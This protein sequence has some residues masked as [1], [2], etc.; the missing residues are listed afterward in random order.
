MWEDRW[1]VKEGGQGSWLFCVYIEPI[2]R[3]PDDLHT[4]TACRLISNTYS[5]VYLASLLLLKM[6]SNDADVPIT[7]IGANDSSGTEQN[8]PLIGSAEFNTIVRS[9]GIDVRAG[10]YDMKRELQEKYVFPEGSAFIPVSA[11]YTVKNN[12]GTQQDITHSITSQ[13]DLDLANPLRIQQLTQLDESDRHALFDPTAAQALET[14]CN[15]S[16][17]TQSS[18]LKSLEIHVKSRDTNGLSVQKDQHSVTLT[19]YTKFIVTKS[20][21][22]SQ[23]GRNVVVAQHQPEDSNCGEARFTSQYTIT[24]EGCM[25]RYPSLVGSDHSDELSDALG[26]FRGPKVTRSTVGATEAE[27]MT[28][29]RAKA[30]SLR[31]QGYKAEIEDLA[32]LATYYSVSE[33]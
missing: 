29:L 24:G 21:W 20:D 1:S 2:R 8:Y 22:N 33:I 4:P 13:H 7:E 10:W 14:L 15:A 11:V 27:M 31:T 12:D 26:D 19:P 3:A 32:A 28:A 16:Q 18:T 25:A 6:S 9:H 17:S 5:A 30:E 23:P